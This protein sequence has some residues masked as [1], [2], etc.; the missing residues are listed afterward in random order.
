MANGTINHPVIHIE[1]VNVGSLA[2]T[3]AQ[4][5]SFNWTRTLNDTPRYAWL[6]QFGG[7]SAAGVTCTLLNTSANGGTLS[8]YNTRSTSASSITA[9]VYYIE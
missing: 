1:T 3:T 9:Q 8:M 5:F 6:A 7:N 2:G 4:N